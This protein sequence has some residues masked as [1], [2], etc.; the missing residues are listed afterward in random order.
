MGTQFCKRIGETVPGYTRHTWHRHVFLH[1]KITGP[2][3][4]ASHLRSHLLQRPPTK[5]RNIS[6]SPNGRRESHQ[7]SRKHEHPHRG[8]S[9]CQTPHQL[10]HQYT[11][12]RVPWHRPGKLLPEHSDGQSR[13]H[14][15]PTRN[16]P[17]RNHRQIQ[18]P[19]KNRLPGDE[20]SF[21]ALLAILIA[22]AHSVGNVAYLFV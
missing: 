12:R 18:P 3:T 21:T 1:M 20:D 5:G 11:G 4:Q 8:P 19:S 22:R 15:P 16:H 2:Q 10:H 6:N 13:I 9:H 14:A 17:R 7:F